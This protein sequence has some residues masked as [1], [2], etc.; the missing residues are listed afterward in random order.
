[1]KSRALRKKVWFKVLSRV[2]R[3][4]VD[5]TIKWVEKVRSNVLSRTL[6]MIA[7]KL[8]GYLEE[9]FMTR[10][11]SVGCQIAERLCTVGERWGNGACASWKYDRFFIRFL[12]VNAVN[13]R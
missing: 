7:S 11:E 6:S 12:G 1:M 10:S 5:L 9:E 13:T 2:E 8:L 4:I 3:A